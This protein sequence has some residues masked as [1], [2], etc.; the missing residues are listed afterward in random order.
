MN[1][2][3][4]ILFAASM[5][6]TLPCIDLHGEEKMT[7]AIERLEKEVY[8]FYTEDKRYCRVIYGIGEGKMRKA[9][10]NSLSKNPMIKSVLP[11]D[12]GGSCIVV[13]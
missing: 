7:S 11:E 2:N 4:A 10:I 12:T 8:R 5:D 3:D 6:Y 1:N 9:V 13:Y